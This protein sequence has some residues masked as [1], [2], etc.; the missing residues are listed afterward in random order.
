[1][2]QVS[3]LVVPKDMMTVAAV[4]VAA[5]VAAVIAAVAAGAAIRG[6]AKGIILRVSEERVS[7]Y[8]TDCVAFCPS[9]LAS[10]EQI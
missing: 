8:R 2:R 6:A 10:T 1:M 4:A 7:N 3:L 5:A 9:R